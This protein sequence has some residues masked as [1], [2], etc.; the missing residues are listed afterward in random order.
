MKLPIGNGTVN[1]IIWMSNNTSSIQSNVRKYKG[2]YYF[3]DMKTASGK[4]GGIEDLW[5]VY[6]NEMLG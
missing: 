5:D 1:F 6:I 2:K 3:I 4:D